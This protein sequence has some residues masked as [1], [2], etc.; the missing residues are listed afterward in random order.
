MD[1]Q[2]HP[3]QTGLNS[4]EEYAIKYQFLISF[5]DDFWKYTKYF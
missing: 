5:L 3:V 4:D 1:G 2:T